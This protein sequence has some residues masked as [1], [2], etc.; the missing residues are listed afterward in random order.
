MTH[1]MTKQEAGQAS[2]VAAQDWAETY[3]DVLACFNADKVNRAL[4]ASFSTSHREDQPIFYPELCSA[5][6]NLIDRK[7]LVPEFSLSGIPQS[8]IEEMRQI[9]N[10]AKQVAAVAAAPPPAPPANPVVV[11]KANQEQ[12]IEDCVNDFKTLPSAVFK[13][14]WMGARRPIYDEVVASGRI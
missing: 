2:R 12:A 6:V 10:K 13:S 9:T 1:S 14:R 11:A 3:S 4:L 5:F 7:V 8:Q